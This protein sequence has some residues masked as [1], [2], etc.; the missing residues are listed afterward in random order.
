MI[1][2]SA[3][4]LIVIVPA[5]AFAIFVSANVMTGEKRLRRRPK[6]LYTSKDIDFRRSLGV[7]L[8]PAI[9]PGNH[10]RILMNGDATFPAMLDAIRAAKTS[11]T[12]ESFIFRDE[13]ACAFC[14]ALTDAAKRGVRIHVLLDWV[15]SR[16]M[17]RSKL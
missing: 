17:D 2:F 12:F 1:E 5:V 8:G 9:L 11:I 4:W 13:I 7:L 6:T 15:G 10:V 16:T 3:L 14:K